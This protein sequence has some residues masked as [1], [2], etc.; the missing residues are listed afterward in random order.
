MTQTNLFDLRTE[1]EKIYDFF[2]TECDIILVWR[3]EYQNIETL[4]PEEYAQFLE[5]EKKK[6]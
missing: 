1:Q 5:Y 6:H 2:L 3:E 4:Y